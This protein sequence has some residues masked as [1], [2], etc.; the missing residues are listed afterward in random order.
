MRT[1]LLHIAL[2]MMAL[3]VTPISATVAAADVTPGAGT[4]GEA[5]DS[6]ARLNQAAGSTILSQDDGSADFSMLL[7]VSLGILGLIWVRRHAA[8]L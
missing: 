8:E 1:S 7:V 6:P 3:L 5:A 4:Y 2:L